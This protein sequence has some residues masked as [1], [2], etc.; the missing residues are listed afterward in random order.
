[1][2]R[3][4]IWAEH[5]SSPDDNIALSPLFKNHFELL[6]P[7]GAEFNAL[8]RYNLRL[9]LVTLS[10]EDKHEFRLAPSP[11]ISLLQDFLAPLFCSNSTDQW[12]TILAQINH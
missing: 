10:S 12:Q 3:S 8:S 1:M 5:Y 6:L 2:L 11:E 7:L 4:R 9:V